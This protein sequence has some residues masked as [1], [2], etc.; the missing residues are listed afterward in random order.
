LLDLFLPLRNNK[1][2]RDLN[3]INRIIKSGKILSLGRNIIKI[4]KEEE[5]FDDLINYF[6]KQSFLT[7]DF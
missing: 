2:I 1:T 7:F 4:D 5:S 3:R 6:C